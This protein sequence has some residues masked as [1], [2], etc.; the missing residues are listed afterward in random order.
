LRVALANGV[1]CARTP[2][3]HTERNATMP[4]LSLLASSSSLL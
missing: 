1:S 2:T 3:T 4:G